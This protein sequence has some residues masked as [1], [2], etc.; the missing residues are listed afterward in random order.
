MNRP[1]RLS[2]SFVKTVNQT[3]RY[4]D[5][6]GG[7]GLSL[8]VKTASAGGFSKIWCQRLRI[9]GRPTDLGLGSYPV[10]ELADARA[11]ALSNRQIAAK[12][13]DPRVRATGIPTFREAAEKVT[14]MHAA[15]W[16]EG[17]KSEAQW[18]SSLSTYVYP[19]IGS[20]AVDKIRA[21]EVMEV[22]LPIW[23]TKPETAQRVRQRIGTVM[24]W[25][26]AQGF[27]EDNPAGEA[28]TAALPKSGTP[29]GH[30]KALPHSEVAGAIALIKDSGAYLSTVLAFQFIV[31]TACRSGE[32]RLATWD[33]I[34]L[35]GQLW[36]IPQER[37]KARREHR[38]P[39]SE[40]SMNVLQ[41]ARE[42]L[43][44]RGLIFP[45]VSGQVLS[46]S[47]VSKLC[48]ENGVNCVPHGF[49]SSFADWCR[50]QRYD[51]DLVD[52]CLAHVRRGVDAAYFR[53]DLL[54]PR[55]TL[56]QEWS[57]Y[58]GHSLKCSR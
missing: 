58:L 28:L 17:S 14:Q 9:N 34:D 47:T 2:A 46:D 21:A 16:K 26:V 56:L 8:L 42:S 30:H 40:G 33:E 50:E 12:G 39:L 29:R 31:L 51:K 41:Q 52:I 27:R 19:S 55:R 43:G 23:T 44:E 57:D 10:V 35:E 32:V 36:T 38:V 7:H 6:R 15:S 25:A 24:K 37:M 53:T 5:G 18:R 49:R 54:S 3:G 20:K 13:Q 48:R 11:A 22:L 1:K 45:A 4:G